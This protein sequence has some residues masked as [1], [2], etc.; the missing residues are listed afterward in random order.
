MD[1]SEIAIDDSGAPI[2]GEDGSIQG[3][4]LVFR[5]ITARRQAEVTSRLLASIVESSSYAIVSQDMRGVVM[6]WNRGAERIL[7]YSADEMIGGTLAALVA[8]G[9]ADRT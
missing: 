3:A 9:L 4:V 5:D 1:G 2:H 8:P 7:G 6:S